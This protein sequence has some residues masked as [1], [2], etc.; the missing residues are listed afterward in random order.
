MNAVMPVSRVESSHAR[1]AADAV[2][3]DEADIAKRYVVSFAGDYH[4]AS[5]GTGRTPLHALI[6]ATFR[7]KT[8]ERRTVLV[9]T[10]LAGFAVNGKQVLDLGCGSGEVSIVAAQLGARVT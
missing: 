7:K 5:E 6:N 4:R 1:G 3:R 9:R 10:W 8:F 2:M